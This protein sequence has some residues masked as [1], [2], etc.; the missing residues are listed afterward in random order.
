MKLLYF[1][2]RARGEPLRML[3]MYSGLEWED[4]IVSMDEWRG[5]GYKEK[6][7]PGRT[8]SKQLPV[9]EF[10]DCSLMPES[11]D[12]AKWIAQQCSKTNPSS[13]LMPKTPEM[14]AKA[15]RL[16]LLSDDHENPHGGFGKA[17]PL[18]NWFSV[19]ESSE[20]LPAFFEKLPTIL[21]HLASELGSGPYFCG[22]SSPTYVDFWIFHYLDNICTLDGGFSLGRVAAAA[23]GDG[24]AG[25]CER[26]KG[27]D[28]VKRRLAERPQCGTQSVGNPG[29]IIH[30]IGNPPEEVFAIKR[31]IASSQ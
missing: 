7:P 12:I 28:A 16:F 30:S 15:E 26:M 22:G 18:L 17:N 29:S 24:L 19:Q 11:L 10:P 13:S 2:L 6:M 1:N 3:L 25:F 20:Q 27:L 8:G 9:L 4:A 23:G 31:V 14:N 5:G 21:A